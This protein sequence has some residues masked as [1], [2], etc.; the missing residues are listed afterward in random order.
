MSFKSL[1]NLFG[2]SGEYRVG[3][4]PF[5]R[6]TYVLHIKGYGYVGVFVDGDDSA[7]FDPKGVVHPSIKEYLKMC[8]VEKISWYN[9]K[10]Y[11]ENS[12]L[13]II[14]F[15]RLSLGYDVKH[16]AAK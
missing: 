13:K 16:N 4:A 10:A 7:V 14:S 2:F 6:G 11:H 5:G 3:D 9:T 15:V 8:N 1:Y 12:D